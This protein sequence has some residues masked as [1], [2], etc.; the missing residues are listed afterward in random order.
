MTYH[1]ITLQ[2]IRDTRPCGSDSLAPGDPETG[3]RLLLT[4]LGQDHLHYDR[5][6]RVSLGDI[7]RSNGPDDA[8][9]C[10]RCLDWTVET[11]RYVL[12]T[13]LLPM[14]RRL[15][16][17]ADDPALEEWIADLAKWQQGDDTVDLRAIERAAWREGAKWAKWAAHAA[18]AAWA[19][20]VE[21]TAQAARAERAEWTEWVAWVEG[22]EWV[23]RAAR[24]TRAAWAAWVAW[25]E[26]AD[27]VARVEGAAWR[28]ERDVQRADLIAAF[29]PLH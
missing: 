18:G 14:G 2:Q 24:V 22:A 7:A 3:W 1:T 21:W 17:T 23:A 16:A 5:T 10:M 26:G 4:S 27:W 29:P 19:E 25:V 13:I 15:S 12:G 20:R 6:L 28:A 11:R 9:W 8:F